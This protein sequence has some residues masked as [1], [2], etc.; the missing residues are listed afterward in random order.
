MEWSIKHFKDLRIWQTAHRLV[1]LVYQVTSRFP[2]MERFGLVT[3]MNRSALSITSNIAE[4]FG[5]ESFKEKVRFYVTAKGSLHELENQLIL[6]HDLNYFSD[7]V[8]AHMTHI[9]TD[10]HK[11]LNA[12]IKKTKD[13]GGMWASSLNSKF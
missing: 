1:L 6:A 3:Q 10:T 9:V 8:D 12:F 2:E 13:L 4:G 11:L 5:R 7:E